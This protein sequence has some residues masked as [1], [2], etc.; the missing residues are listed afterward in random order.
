MPDIVNSLADQYAADFTS[1]EDYL[2]KRVADETNQSHPHAHM[3]SGHVQGK[4]LSL[5]SS[6]LQPLRILE[7]G[8]FTGYSALCL[9]T[10]LPRDGQL[11]TIELRE[12]DAA[13]ARAYFESSTHQKKIKL[14]VGEAKEI[15]Q[16][17]NETWD[18]VFIDADKTGYIEYYELILPSVRQNGLIIADNVL[19][20]G[21]VLEQTITTKNGIA[22]HTFNQHVQQ[23]KRVEQVLL[24]MR[25]GLLIIRK[26]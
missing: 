1:P 2:L 5:V 23:D 26:I 17:L 22:I 19:F 7:I 21:Q 6:L 10:G 12:Q 9:A 20:H 8:T 13:T 4:F 16:T 15:I 14:H 3:L 25:D 24:T 18:I 11:H